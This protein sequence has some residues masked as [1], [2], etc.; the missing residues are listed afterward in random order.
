MR[1]EKNIRRMR[2]SLLI[3]GLLFMVIGCS[4][5]DT[6]PATE[7]ITDNEGNEYQ[8]VE[9]GSQVWM[10]ENLRTSTYRNGDDIPIG[11][12]N[13]DWYSANGGA[14]AFQDS[15]MLES[16]GMVYNWYAVD[17]TRGL[18]PEGWHVPSDDEWVILLDYLEGQGYNNSLQTDTLGAGNALK[19]CRQENSPL[20]GDCD[21][22][23]HP[24]WQEP[25]VPESTGYHYGTD[26][27]GF[28]GLPVGTRV[29]NG[30]FVGTGRSTQWW[31]STGDPHPEI[32]RSVDISYN[33][34]NVDRTQNFIHSGLGVRC[35]RSK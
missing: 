19:S 22:S 24:R 30:T 27:F 20:G 9:I 29:P 5:D 6:S 2:L 21:T 33:R 4:D 32:A 18:C 25:G 7:T 12:S 8:T 15:E 3:I 17:D 34:G 1:S 26:A 13:S 28:A 11:L 31:T 16:Y 23:Q 14:A 35:I 10:A